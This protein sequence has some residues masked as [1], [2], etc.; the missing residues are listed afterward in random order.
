MCIS[1]MVGR[2][3]GRINNKIFETEMN[4]FDQNA[5]RKL[6]REGRKEMNRTKL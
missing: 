3:T 1:K 6:E 2:G 4:I 5:R